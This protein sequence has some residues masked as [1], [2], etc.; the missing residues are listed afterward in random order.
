MQNRVFKGLLYVKFQSF[1]CV[2]K[3]AWLQ[4]LSRRFDFLFWEWINTLSLRIVDLFLIRF[5]LYLDDFGP[6]HPA[7][8]VAV[9][10]SDCFLRAFP[11]LLEVEVQQGLILGAGIFE[12]WTCFY[13][14]DEVRHIHHVKHRLRHVKLRFT[15]LRIQL[16]TELKVLK[17]FFV[18]L[19]V[20]VLEGSQHYVDGFD[21][22]RNS[23]LQIVRCFN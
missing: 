21:F 11:A 3:T 9:V 18:V 12:S 23:F 16:F 14:L 10:K 17:S 19:D 6:K 1:L 2:G 22:D 7:F 13:A 8:C 5:V 15:A 4:L 20:V